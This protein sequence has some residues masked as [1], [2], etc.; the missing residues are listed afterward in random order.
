MS[1]GVFTFLAFSCLLTGGFSLAQNIGRFEEGKHLGLQYIAGAKFDRAAAKFEEI[2]DQD[3][4]DPLVAEYLAIAYL[5]GDDRKDH[6]ELQ[7]KAFELMQKSIELGGKASLLV[8]HSHEKLGWLQGK[9]LN[10]YC[11]G[12]L[13]VTPARLSFTAEVH[14]SSKEDHSFDLT[15]SDLKITGPASGDDRGL[16]QVKTK[17]RDYSLVPASWNRT[18]AEL[19]IALVQKNLRE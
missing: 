16:F 6:P 19:F 18:D 2:W 13:S 15:R 3:Q 10:D 11:A 1:R 4:T 12:K 9:T 7:R 17:A 14:A 5:N 8:R